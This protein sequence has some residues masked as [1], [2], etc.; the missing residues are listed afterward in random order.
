MAGMIVLLL[1][2][3]QVLDWRWLAALVSAGVL[4]G[5]RR[6]PREI[7]S[8]Y[9]IAQQMDRRLDLH[10]SLST[11]FF[12]RRLA[13]DRGAAQGM[14]DAQLGEA[15]RIAAGVDVVSAV[16]LA[17]PRS[18][19]AMAILGLIASSLFALRY[20]I[21]RRLDLRPPLATLVFD[22]FHFSSEPQSAEKKKREV[23]RADD[24]LKPSGLQLNEDAERKAG[25]DGSNPGLSAEAPESDAARKSE[26][27]SSKQH[28][29]ASVESLK[30]RQPGAE[31]GEGASETAAG[32]SEGEKDASEEAESRGQ[33]SGRSSASQEAASSQHESNGLL[34]KFRDAMSNLL[35]RLRSQP[36]QGDSQQMAPGETGR[37]S[38]RGRRERGQKASDR[39]GR[40]TEGSPNGNAE[41]DEQGQGA[42]NAESGPGKQGGQDTEQATKQGQSG[43]GRDDGSKAIREAEQ[44]AAM[45]KISE[46]IGKRSKNL[47]GEVMVEVASGKQE[48]R[49][50]YSDQQAKHTDS[51][52]EI[53][54]DEIPLAYQQYVQQ[55]FDEVRKPPAK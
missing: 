53:H 43:I 4:A 9:G 45:G 20:G 13:K 50:A 5:F 41:G 14:R 48:L 54:R 46:I 47:T 51:G 1:L 40:R 12:Y 23:R 52:G 17:F 6:L 7:P 31:R 29:S 32:S 25:A 30:P 28:A 16:P 11:A 27:D 21:S 36:K 33:A 19:Y 49:T 44:L 35:S 8:R 22:A 39:N 55:Y 18:V 26:A 38:G 37:D 3:T 10:D 15:E 24:K 42:E 2:G 34:D